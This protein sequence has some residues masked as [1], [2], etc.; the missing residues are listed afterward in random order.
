MERSERGAAVVLD[1]NVVL[2]WLVFEDPAVRPLADALADGRLSWIATEAMLD[3]L[4]HVLTRPG[5]ERWSERC[6]QALESAA[7]AV[8]TVEMPACDR[9]IPVC[10]D[11]SDQKF[12]ELALACNAPWLL[13]RDKELLRLARAARAAGTTVC[14]PAGWR[15]AG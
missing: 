2:D 13:T 14:P 4:R 10:R 8:R 3:E 5:L 15:A 11:A 9:P 1:T 6:A 12:I 7:A